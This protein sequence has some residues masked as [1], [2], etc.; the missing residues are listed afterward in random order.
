MKRMIRLCLVLLVCL[1]AFTGCQCSHEWAQADCLTPKTCSK[2]DETEGEALGHD[3][4][5]ASCAAP[6]TCTRCALTEGDV[7]EHSRT[8][9]SCAAPKT[10]TICVLTEGEALEH[11]WAE[12]NYQAPKT[13]TVCGETEGEALPADFEELGLQIDI[14]EVNVPHTL[15]ASGTEFALCI[16]SYEVYSGDDAHEA[17]EGYEWRTVELS[18]EALE[19]LDSL[20]VQIPTY[21]DYNNYYDLEGFNA[22]MAP[23]QTN[24]VFALQHTVNHNGVDYTEC[25]MQ[26][27]KDYLDQQSSV[28]WEH[29]QTLSFR[30]PVGFDGIVVCVGDG[31]QVSS[32]Y[33]QYYMDYYKDDNTL[34]FRLS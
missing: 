18:V 28:K 3:W 14:T 5:E 33:Q 21:A 13:C 9:V 23:V 10:C 11:T 19:N 29:Q 24:A 22:S 34:F 32:N 17:L 27:D 15:T 25:L 12:A 20:S 7:L 6:K 8:E 30:V 1:L 31:A 4:A 26:V 16:K 2:C